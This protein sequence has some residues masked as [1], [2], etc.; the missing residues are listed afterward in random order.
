M[1][2]DDGERGSAT[3]WMV[4]LAG[5]LALVGV[6]TVL[7]GAAV[8]ARH[9]ATSAADLVA[10]AAAGRAVLGD[11]AACAV[12]EEVA[13]ANEA[14]VDSCAVTS[15]AVVEVR[16][17]VPVR[18]GP[19]GVVD[20]PARARAGPAPPD[21]EPAPEQSDGGGADS[22]DAHPGLR[23][24]VRRET[25]R[26]LGRLAERPSPIRDRRGARVDPTLR[27]SACLCRRTRD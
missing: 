25:A 26:R 15:G 6:A 11:P 5:L 4:A 14:V 10:L 13:A 22:S 16:V 23:V 7:V 18:L 17:H 19:L 20:A 2:A 9:R 27:R 8:V 21:T 3:V 12:A 1:P 24:R